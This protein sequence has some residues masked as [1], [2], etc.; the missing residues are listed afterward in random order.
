MAVPDYQTLMLPILKFFGANAGRAVHQQ[1]LRTAISTELQ[2]S[3]DDLA[4]I[5]PS[6]SQTTFANR[7]GWACTYLKKGGTS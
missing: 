6:G 5:L 4:E 3:E 1:E 7:V 2:L